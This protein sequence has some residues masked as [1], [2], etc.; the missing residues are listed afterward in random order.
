MAVSEAGQPHQFHLAELQ[1][2][3]VVAEAALLLAEAAAE[4]EAEAVAEAEAEGYSHDGRM[5][6]PLRLFA[7]AISSISL[8]PCW[9]PIPNPSPACP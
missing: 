7:S 9:K 5:I 2:R 8:G 1:D 3:V 6:G 4:A